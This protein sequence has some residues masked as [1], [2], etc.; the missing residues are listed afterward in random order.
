MNQSSQS[1]AQNEDAG[2]SEYLKEHEQLLNQY[3]DYLGSESEV[4]QEDIDACVERI[5]ELD[6]LILSILRHQG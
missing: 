2:F 1:N 3:F 6:E 4:S 5:N